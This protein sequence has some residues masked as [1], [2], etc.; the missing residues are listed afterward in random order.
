[1]RFSGEILA[2]GGGGH[3][4]LIPSELAAQFSRKNPRVL[5]LING[6]EYHSRVARYGG[7]SYLGLRKDLLRSIGADTG[8]T[9]E[10][11]LSEEPEPQPDPQSDPQSAPEP[12][13]PEELTAAL[14]ADPAARAAFDA[15][16]PSHQREYVRW[17]AEGKR[18]ETRTE[19]AAK[20]VRRI[21][22]PRG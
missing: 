5:A 9:V 7:R 13:E 19:R 2:G 18:S 16:P 14:A 22:A 21:R 6:A 1:M 10:I 3:A 8:D 12:T 20:T 17:I 15:L 4:V 11:E